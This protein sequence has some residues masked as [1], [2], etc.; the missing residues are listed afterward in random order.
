MRPKTL[1]VLAVI[2]LV[3]AFSLSSTLVKRAESPG[4]LVAFWRLIAVS[5][6][7]NAVLCGTGRSVTRADVRQVWLPGVF[8]GLNLAVFFAGATHNSVANA[9]LIGSLA[10]FLI[11]PVGAWLFAEYI[12]PRALVF[13]VIA[14]GGA[15]SCC[16]RPPGGDASL[17][18][19]VLGVI[20]MLLLVAPGRRAGLARR[21]RAGRR[22]GGRSRAG[23]VRRRD[24]DGVDHRCA[25]RGGRRGGR[26]ALPALT[27]PHARPAR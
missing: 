1:G 2:G 26:L 6:L 7:W 13:A 17:E 25:R 11:V 21:C 19:N 4:V 27:A 5:I 20:A 16:E 10:P 9:A 24:V 3:V 12:N 22:S 14:F 15:C 8:F 18:G 23:G